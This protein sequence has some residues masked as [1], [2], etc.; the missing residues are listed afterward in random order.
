[1]QFGTVC[2][3]AAGLELWLPRTV[4]RKPWQK[5]AYGEK[6]VVTQ[7]SL[8]TGEKQNHPAIP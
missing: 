6:G 4:S 2:I 1:M 5:S 3:P 7:V 8:V